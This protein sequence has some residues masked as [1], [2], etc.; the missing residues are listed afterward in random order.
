MLVILFLLEQTVL[1]RYFIS[2]T[3]LGSECHR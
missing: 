3:F 2:F 1:A